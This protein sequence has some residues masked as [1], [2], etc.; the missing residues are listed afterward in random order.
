MKEGEKNREV[1]G[2]IDDD[3]YDSGNAIQ[4]YNQKFKII[5]P[6]HIYPCQKIDFFGEK[7]YS[8]P[9]F[10]VRESRMIWVVL[11]LIL[12]AEQPWN[13]ISKS[14][15]QRSECQGY[16]MMYLTKIAN[17]FLIVDLL[18]YSKY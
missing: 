1:I 3:V 16:I 12:H 8:V 11:S 13:I 7:M 10:Q 6:S 4:E 2:V 5:W 9:S 14:E 17:L 15:M 18:I